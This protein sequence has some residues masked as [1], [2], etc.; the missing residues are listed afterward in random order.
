MV[1]SVHPDVSGRIKSFFPVCLPC[2]TVC[3][4]YGS[5]GHTR[6]SAS[7]SKEQQKRKII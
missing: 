7:G 1:L 4:I 6:L 3:S 5:G 2:V